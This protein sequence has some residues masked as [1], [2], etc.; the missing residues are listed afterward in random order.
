MAP[1]TEHCSPMNRT[2]GKEVWLTQKA[3]EYARPVNMQEPTDG[4]LWICVR[5]PF[6][7]GVNDIVLILLL[8][9]AHTSNPITSNACSGFGGWKVTDNS[10]PVEWSSTAFF[11]CTSTGLV[12]ILYVYYDE[13][14]DIQWN[15]AWA[16][17]KSWRRGLTDLPMTQA[18]FHRIS[19]LKS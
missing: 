13:R 15:I 7:Q 10:H 11:P 6:H 4:G 16:Q 8:G 1:N 9:V 17:E 5:H 19:R 12:Y 18:I 14:K 2:T 3:G